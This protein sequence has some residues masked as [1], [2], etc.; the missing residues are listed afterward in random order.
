MHTTRSRKSDP[1]RC[2]G[3]GASF[4]VT[5]LDDRT[6]ERALLP[7]A[8]L[9]VACP[10]CGRMRSVSLPAGAERTLEVELVEG[11]EPDEGGGG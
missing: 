4:E 10:Q 3:C 5:Y 2:P 11:P 9:D 1:H 7:M 6:G 8:S